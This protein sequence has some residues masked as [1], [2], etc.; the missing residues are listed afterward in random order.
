[1]LDE[2]WVCRWSTR[3]AFPLPEAAKEGA[4]VAVY[5]LYLLCSLETYF[6]STIDS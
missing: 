2:G 5:L 6:L 4:P 1:M 3:V